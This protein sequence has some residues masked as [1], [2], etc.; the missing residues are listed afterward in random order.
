MRRGTRAPGWLSTYLVPQVSYKAHPRHREGHL[1]KL[2]V[3]AG[4]SGT[5]LL[6]RN[7]ES[8]KGRTAGVCIT[9]SNDVPSTS[10]MLHYGTEMAATP[11]QTKRQ[12]LS[13]A[14]TR[15]CGHFS[16]QLVSE[17]FTLGPHFS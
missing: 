17:T 13:T 11:L 3:K 2:P 7:A 1:S 14:H 9:T 15:H 4:S 16:K 8:H 12:S 6:P 5:Q 10:H